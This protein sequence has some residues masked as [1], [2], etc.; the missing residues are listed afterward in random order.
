MNETPP[1]LI[2]TKRTQMRHFCINDARSVIEFD[3]HDVVHQFL[4]PGDR[5]TSVE[6]AEGIIQ[7]VWQKEYKEYGYARYALI[8]KPENKVIGFCGFKFE[9]E[10][11]YPDLGYRIAP[12]YWGKGIVS[13]AVTAL[14]DYAKHTLNLKKIIAIATVDNIASNRIIQNAGLKLSKQITHAD[15][16]Q[17]FYQNWE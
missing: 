6:Q 8:Y 13:E 5:V 1:I 10:F 3:N 2:D 12:A 16:L 4:S 7:S 9:Q 17:N 15:M 11:G 14:M